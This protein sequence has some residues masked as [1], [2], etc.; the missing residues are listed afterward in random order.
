MWRRPTAAELRGTGLK[1]SHYKEPIAEVWPECWP[2]V[3][4]YLKYRTQ[5]IQG[6]GGPSGLNYS[7]LFADLDRSG[8]EGDEREDIMDHIRTIEAEVLAEIY[9][10]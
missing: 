3:D 2:A 4:L 6:P 7:I 5:W 8:I 1:Q 9:K 10:E